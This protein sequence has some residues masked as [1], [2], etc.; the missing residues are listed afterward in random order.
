LLSALPAGKVKVHKRICYLIVLIVLSGTSLLLMCTQR[1]F[2]DDWIDDG[3]SYLCLECYDAVTLPAC[4]N[5]ILCN[6]ET[7]TICYK[8]C[9]DCAKALHRCQM[10]TRERH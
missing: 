2:N 10:C 8:Y 3:Y 1:E 4:G 7:R 9:Y 5:C 6:A